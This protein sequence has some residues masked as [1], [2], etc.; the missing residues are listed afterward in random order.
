VRPVIELVRGQFPARLTDLPRPPR[1]IFVVGELPGGPCVA[2]VGTRYATAEG[3]AFAR[4]LA[5]YLASR[6]VAVVS[7][8]AR[9]IDRAAHEGALA[10]GG[11]TL[12]VS[13]SSYDHPYPSKHQE[14]Y[15][16]AIDAGGAYVSLH[17]SAVKPRR[18]QFFA[19]NGLLVALA[20]AVVV[21]ES[22]L[23]GG[24]MNAA[25][26][27]RT[28]GRPLLAVP[29]PPWSPASAGCLAELRRGAQMLVG[30]ADVLTVLAARQL[31]PVPSR[32]VAWGETLPLFGDEP[33]GAYDPG[34]GVALDA[35]AAESSD[36]NGD[37]TAIIGMGPETP[38]GRGDW[39]RSA[40]DL[41]PESGDL[42]AS[43]RVLRSLS[44][45]PLHVDEIARATGLPLPRLQEVLLTLTLGGALATH[46]SGLIALVNARI[47]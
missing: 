7:G 23:R 20:H 34:S 44:K 12:V 35:P 9:G 25:K 27:A 45:G 46:P 5:T 3:T 10:G 30:P 4:R 8:G 31:H 24:G 18:E 36:R 13:P 39:S 33:G 41:S 11:V 40:D 19:R 14:L 38:A 15:E 17:A 1:S 47:T 32:E 21:V 26:W 22:R 29:G 6:G 37:Q 43:K 28:I 2:I 42:G 16:R